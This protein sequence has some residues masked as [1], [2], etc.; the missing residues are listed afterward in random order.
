[1]TQLDLTNKSSVQAAQQKKNMPVK[2]LSQLIREKMSTTLSGK[3]LDTFVADVVALTNIN[4][5][6]AKCDPVSIIG[7]CLQAQTLGLSLNQQMGQAWIVPFENKRLG[8]TMATFQIGYRGFISLAIRT[9]EYV[10]LNVLEIKDGE[11]KSW[12]PLTE[13]I[14]V[15]LIEDGIERDKAETIG[16]YAMFEYRNGFRKA[17]YWS[18]S[19]MD[20]HARKYSQPYKADIRYG[21]QSSIWSTDFDSMAKKTMLRQLISH[22]GYMSTDIITALTT[23][24]AVATDIGKFDYQEANDVIDVEAHEQ[25]QPQAIEQQPEP[26]TIEKPKRQ[27]KEPAPQQEVIDQ[28]TG[29]VFSEADIADMQAAAR[30]DEDKDPFYGD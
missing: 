13:D 28:Q 14:E 20:A 16:Y 1:M 26:V 7:A 19:K 2:P 12:N 5:A 3:K 22:W 10:K 9:G 15:D 18:R 8:K 29:E 25:E 21:K 30:A 27:K 4:P 17:M 24:G 11:L 23:D 6:I